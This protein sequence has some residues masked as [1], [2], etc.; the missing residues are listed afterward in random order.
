MGRSNKSARRRNTRLD[1][2]A[3]GERRL[4]P[5]EISRYRVKPEEMVVPDGQCRAWGRRPKA[6]FATEAKARIALDQAQKQR[7][8]MGSAHVEKRYYPCPEGGCGG[9]HLTSREEFDEDTWKARRE[10]GSD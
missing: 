1:R 2:R 5:R 4:P 3:K 7:A 10:T 8:R 6:R 9:W